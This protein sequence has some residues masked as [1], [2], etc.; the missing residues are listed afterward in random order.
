VRVTFLT[1][2]EVLALHSDQ[3]H[4]YGGRPGIRDL[5]LVEWAVATPAAAFAGQRLHTT[6]SEMAAAYLFHVVRNHPFLDGNKRTGLITVL[7]FLGL[8][9]QRLEAEPD[10]L[11][12]LVVGVADGR[13]TKPEVSVFVQRHLRPSRGG[14]RVRR[15]RRPR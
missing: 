5:T 1:V 9:G 15:E 14:V 6:I 7:T 3:I 13:V 10:R 4:R 2:G 8:N 12:E 11:T